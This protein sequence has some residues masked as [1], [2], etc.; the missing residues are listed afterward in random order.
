MASGL[1]VDFAG[2][3]SRSLDRYLDILVNRLGCRVALCE[4]YNSTCDDEVSIQRRVTRI[5]TPGTVI[6][7]RF[8]DSHAYN[9]LLAV[10][11]SSREGQDTIGLAWVDVSVGEFFT[12]SS[13]LET[14]KDDI[15][16]IRPREVILP[17]TNKPSD[18]VLAD[19]AEGGGMAAYNPIVRALLADTS[20]MISYWPDSSFNSSEGRQ[21]LRDMLNAPDEMIE[22]C[23]FGSN[24]VTHSIDEFSPGETAA[25]MALLDYVNSTLKDGRLKL[26]KPVRVDT[27]DTLRIDSAAMS[28]LEIVKS[29]REG[30]RTDSL[31]AAMDHTVSRAGSRLLTR[32]LSSPLTSVDIIEKRQ[33][34]VE[35]FVQHRQ[36]L[37]QVRHL[38]RHIADAQ[39]ALQRLALGRGQHQELLDIGWTLQAVKKIQTEL[40]EACRRVSAATRERHGEIYRAVEELARFLNPLDSVFEHITVAFD[41]EKITSGEAKDQTYGFVYPYYNEKLEYLHR[42]LQ[43]LYVQRDALQS[44][45]RAICGNSVSLS[46]NGAYKHIVEINASQ[47]TKLLSHYQ[48]TL[49]NKTKSKHRY[50]LDE[51]TTLS[52]SMENT[53][54][55]IAEIENE[56]LT[57]T[58]SLVLSQ[59]SSIIRNCYTLAQLDVLASFAWSALHYSY[60]RPK[61]TAS[62]ETVIIGGRHPVVEANL[63]R[64]GRNFVKNDCHLGSEQ[65]IWLLTGPNMGGKSTFLRQNAI[66]TLLAHIGS[67]VPAQSAEIGITDSIFSRVG[68]ADSLAQDQ[69]TFMVEMTETANIL[70]HATSRSLVIMD[71][72]GR[73]TSTSD[74]LSLA[75]GIMHYL[76]TRIGCRTLF[77]THYHELADLITAS[78]FRATK[79]FMTSLQGT[80]DG[81][82]TYLHRVQPGVCRQSHGIKVAAL[83]GK[84]IA[85]LFF[86]AFELIDVLYVYN[87]VYQ[88][89]CCIPLLV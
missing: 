69:S 32:W 29:L 81:G 63:A 8:L 45:L 16:R 55:Q 20:V 28:S 36:V 37:E 64:K 26:G 59:S 33:N 48:A 30:R 89:K 76:E 5:I 67:F 73:G 47:A 38:L 42:Y 80:P 65:R 11:P 17:E 3:P 24:H 46:S 79:C 27:A 14:F 61:L 66:I 70:K 72:V 35:F 22:T 19:V 77:A 2:F 10:K 13:R 54:A 23:S 86:I 58:I 34:V 21:A 4:Q 60:V 71:E 31:L 12:Q 50:Q 39:R 9:Y 49:V 40:N 56:V 18:D 25:S 44:R 85:S 82:F 83:A 7:E 15:A 1:V 84:H 53:H 62:N 78:G 6:E 43:E 51:W 68:A 74:G 41:H 75:Y 52:I 57:E 88:M 87:Q